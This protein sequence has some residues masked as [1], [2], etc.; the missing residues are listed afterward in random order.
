[1]SLIIFLLPLPFIEV[2]SGHEAREGIRL[3]AMQ[4][5]GD[6]F[7]S[8]V[9]R[10]PPLYYWLSGLAAALRGGTVD[11]ISLRVPSGMLASAGVMLVFLLGQHVVTWRGAAWAGFLLLTSP[12]YVQ[13]SHSSRTDMTLCFFVTCGLLLFFRFHTQS[14]QPDRRV[15]WQAY[16]LHS[17]FALTL[18]SKGPVGL[19][20]V[21]LPIMGFALWRREGSTLQPMLQPGPLLLF[22]LLCGGWYG[23]AFWGAGDTFWRTQIMEENVS[24][25]VGGI[26]QMA[27]L[28]YLGP[29]FGVFAPWSVLFPF[30]WWRAIKERDKE[31]GPFFLAL[32]WI[33][34]V[35]FFQFAAYKRARYLLPALPASALLVGWWLATQLPQASERVRHW[36]WWKPTI[37]TLTVVTV[38]A[39]VM[40]WALLL[41]AQIS[42]TFSCRILQVIP[43]REVRVQAEP[44][45]SWLVTHFR[46][47]VTWLLAF[48]S[49]VFFMLWSLWR[50]RYERAFVSLIGALILAYS[51]LYPSWLIVASRADSPRPYVQRIVAQLGSEASVG[52]ISPYDEKGVPVLFA[53]QERKRLHDVQWPWGMPQPL[54]ATGYYLVTEDRRQ[55]LV[56]DEKGAWTEV[57]RDTGPTAWPITLFF[58]SAS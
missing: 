50:A 34:T 3:R 22:M 40:G 25:F 30:A 28:Y 32:W 5:S 26:D 24:R 35:L 10:K 7:F 31:E 9:L 13:Q 36:R 15:S 14:R 52:F 41:G 37:I 33:S 16:V 57:L 4:A 56:S 20:L 27:P 18:L 46:L 23:S 55:E 45:C 2:T 58:Y 44:Y 48:T 11:A 6:W 51:I 8:E 38:C 29:V 53:L 42:D 39:L 19:V 54:L 49:I 1:L 17:V 43:A 12:L 47:G 21:G